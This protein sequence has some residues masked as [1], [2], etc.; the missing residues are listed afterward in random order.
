MKKKWMSVEEVV[1]L[2][3]VTPDT[4]WRWGREGKFSARKVGRRWRFNSKKVLGEWV[5]TVR[6]QRLSDDPRADLAKFLDLVE[7]LD[8]GDAAGLIE[9]TQREIFE[10]ARSILAAR[11]SK[12][13]IARGVVLEVAR[14][15]RGSSLFDFLATVPVPIQ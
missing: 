2:F 11:G 6:K 4:V 14:V 10:L 9:E 13:D 5:A 1:R 3:G 8:R 7:E 15:L 12:A